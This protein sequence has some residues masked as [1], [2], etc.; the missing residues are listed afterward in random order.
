MA[1]PSPA[2][3]AASELAS[4][5]RAMRWHHRIDL[6]SGLVTP[7]LA[8]RLPELE[9]TLPEMAGGS[10]LDVGAWDG[11]YSFLAERRGAARVVALDHYVWGVD[12][13][14]RNVYLAECAARR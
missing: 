9:R 6:G 3:A 5:V 1:M 4:R 2:A 14:A 8:D 13:A 11:Y 12:L 10:V 7:G